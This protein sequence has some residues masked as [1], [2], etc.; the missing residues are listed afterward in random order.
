MIPNIGHADYLGLPDKIGLIWYDNRLKVSKVNNNE[1]FLCAAANLFSEY[2]NH[3]KGKVEHQRTIESFI[4]ALKKIW[5]EPRNCKF[6]L[7]NN[8]KQERIIKYNKLLSDNSK[9]TLSNYNEFTWF[10]QAAD[11]LSDATYYW[12]KD[13]NESSNW[14]QFQEAAKR[15]KEFALPF[16]N[17]RLKK[18]E[19]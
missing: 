14:Y 1:R 10:N 8:E 13:D 4:G 7:F 16:I 9:I 19:S 18:Y 15:H 2:K 17:E 11:K 6:D 12:K 5:G 3:L